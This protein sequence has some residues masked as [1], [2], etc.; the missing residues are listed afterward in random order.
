MRFALKFSRLRFNL[1]VLSFSLPYFLFHFI[2]HL[3]SHPPALFHSALSSVSFLATFPWPRGPSTPSNCLAV[4]RSRAIPR[5]NTN[6]LRVLLHQENPTR[7][8]RREPTNQEEQKARHQHKSGH[9]RSREIRERKLEQ[10][11]SR[12][13]A[14][15]KVNMWS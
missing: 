6:K 14:I 7:A 3:R 2:C 10:I 9:P 8:K 5:S 1:S 12:Q 11:T 13:A 4:E 15:R